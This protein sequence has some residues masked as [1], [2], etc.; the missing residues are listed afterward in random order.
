MSSL[1]EKSLR[2]QYSIAFVFPALVDSMKSP[3]RSF[4]MC[5]KD[6][7]VGSRWLPESYPPQR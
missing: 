1:L 3:P 6:A 7:R 2:S 4:Q 5:L